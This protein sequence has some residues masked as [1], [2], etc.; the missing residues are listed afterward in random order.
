MLKAR[1]KLYKT[2]KYYIFLR[3]LQKFIKIS[4]PSNYSEIP[5]KLLQFFQIILKNSVFK[6]SRI[7][8]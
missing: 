7:F 2:Q 6:V 1:P 3:F 5:Q 8:L 4:L